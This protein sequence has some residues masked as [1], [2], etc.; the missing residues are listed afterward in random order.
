M[1]DDFFKMTQHSYVQ[2]KAALEGFAH[3]KPLSARVGSSQV[4]LCVVFGDQDQWIPSA[5]VDEWQRVSRGTT[6]LMSGVGHTP[7]LENAD[8]TTQIIAEFIG[9]CTE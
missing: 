9:S 4:P 8:Q 2:A 7:P 6:Q 1:I 3:A 5:C